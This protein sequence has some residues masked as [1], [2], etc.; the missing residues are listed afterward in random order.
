MART[1]EH[2]LPRRLVETIVALTVAG[3]VVLLAGPYLYRLLRRERLRTAAQEVYTLVVAAR[4]QAVKLNQ[5]V[6][7]WIEP[8]TRE[9][10]AWADAAP[11]NF[12]RDPGE[13]VVLRFRIRSG[14]FFRYAPSGEVNDAN[15]V[16]FDGYRGDR[17]IVDRVVFHPDGT[18]E[19]PQAPN[20]KAPARP[21]RVTATVSYGSINCNP[22]DSCRGIYISDRSTGRPEASGNTFRIGV[23]DFGPTGRVSLLKW[24]P[25][26]QGGNPGETNY[27]PP[28]W[29]WVD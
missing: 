17:E 3:I 5:Q 20:S 10:V 28:P 2:R 11:L 26:S 22:G 29:K 9:A 7:L 25:A 23:N 13:A 18:L 8:A 16:S 14:V 1:P 27:V 15:S 19:L 21:G 4:L 6:V 24:V 12:V